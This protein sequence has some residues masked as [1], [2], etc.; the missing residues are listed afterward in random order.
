MEDEDGL[1]EEDEEEGNADD[2]DDAVF[3]VDEVGCLDYILKQYPSSAS[4]VLP[5]FC[6]PHAFAQPI[7]SVYAN[8]PENPASSSSA[9]GNLPTGDYAPSVSEK[10]FVSA[11]TG[12]AIELVLRNPI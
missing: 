6:H 1:E 12:R 11:S 5:S 3:G 4:G 7:D 10:C 2:V 8:F 9:S